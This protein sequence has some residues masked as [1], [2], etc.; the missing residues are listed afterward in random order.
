MYNVRVRMERYPVIGD[1]FCQ[2]GTT[3]ILTNKGWITLEN[4]NINKH[5]V[6]TFNKNNSLTYIY[7]SDKYEYEHNGAFYYYKNK[8]VYI[9]CTPNHKLYI[10]ETNSQN[11]KLIEAQYTCD[12][13]YTMKNNFINSNID[14]DTFN[15][16]GI[17][18]NVND[19]LPFI[20]IFISN[21]YIKNNM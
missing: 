1:K 3:E 13:I 7:P 10:K 20:G 18:Y 16:N 19:M 9:E 6:A 8:N 11:Y 4:L 21:G 17:K 5:K 14:V 12:K 2:K 15:I